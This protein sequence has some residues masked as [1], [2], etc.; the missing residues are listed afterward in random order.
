MEKV[1]SFD[2]IPAELETE[3]HKYILGGQANLWTEYIPTESQAEY[4]LLPRMT[5]LSEVLWT[6]KENKNWDDFKVRLTD[7]KSTYDDMGV[8]YA[9]HIFKAEIKD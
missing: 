8:N 6:M 5:A 4:M 2:P 7:F 1:Y 3:K 9:T